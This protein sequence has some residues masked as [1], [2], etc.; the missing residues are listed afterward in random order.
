MQCDLDLSH[1]KPQVHARVYDLI[2][3]YWP[4]F[5]A[6]GV[7]VPVKYYKCIIDT[8]DFLP[9]FKGHPTRKNN[10]LGS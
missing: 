4:V 7:F 5:D 6:N 8:G 10:A 9:Q 3:K 2:K 1:L